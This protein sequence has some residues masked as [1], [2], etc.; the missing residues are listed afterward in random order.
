MKIKILAFCLE[1]QKAA[2]NKKVETVEDIVEFNDENLYELTCPKG[3]KCFTRLQENKFE[4]LFDQGAMALIDGYSRE[5]V[6]SIAS[7]LERFI[8]Y[9]LKVMAAHH[10]VSYEKYSKTWK[11]MAKQSERQLGAFYFSQ[12]SEWGEVLFQ[13]NEN[14]T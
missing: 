1:C 8:E 5:S 12:T 11:L 9:F 4:L 2:E 3:H 14:Q 7:S 10:K 13:L 6:A